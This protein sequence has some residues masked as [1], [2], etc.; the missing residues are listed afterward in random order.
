MEMAFLAYCVFC[1]L[2][3][4]IC[5]GYHARLLC[6]GPSSRS[7]LFLICAKFALAPVVFPFSVYETFFDGGLQS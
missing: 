6:R 2:G 4:L 7:L 5:L 3:Q 1:Y